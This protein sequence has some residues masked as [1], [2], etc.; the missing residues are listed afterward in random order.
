MNKGSVT[1]ATRATSFL[2]LAPRTLQRKCAC[3]NQTMGGECHSCGNQN[4]ALQ[5]KP[6]H[7]GLETPQSNVV[8]P[9][10]HD[11][12]HSPGQPLDPTT[13]V[14]MESRFGHEFSRVRVHTDLVANRSADVL[15]ARAYTSRN[16]IF[17]GTGQYDQNAKEGRILLAHELVHVVQQQNPSGSAGHTVTPYSNPAEIEART[18]SKSIL[19][20]Q[21]RLPV[22]TKVG[23][24]SQSLSLQGLDPR[25]IYCALH[26]AVCLGLSENPP[27]AA[28]C[29]ANF[30]SRCGGAMASSAQSSTDEAF[31]S[32][33]PS[34]TSSEGEG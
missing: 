10:V 8:P 27:A 7:S 15:G 29:W 16:H 26:A 3:G 34:S 2:P 1:Q 18:V 17:F 30:A 14:F 22:Q 21:S 13:R 23:L 33:A 6:Q 28:L 25:K 20:G 19:E 9:I 4:L 5:R 11:V 24:N 31:A 12:L 32:A